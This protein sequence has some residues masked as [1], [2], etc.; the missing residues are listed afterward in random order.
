[1]N[2]EGLVA[3]IECSFDTNS[4]RY[5]MALSLFVTLHERY[6]KVGYPSSA[7]V[8]VPKGKELKNGNRRGI[9]GGVKSTIRVPLA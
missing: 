3:A 5:L 4:Q 8:V 9:T 1:M 2:G 6:V 7:V